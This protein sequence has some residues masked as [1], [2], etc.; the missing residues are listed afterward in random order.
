MITLHRVVHKST[1]HTDTFEMDIRVSDIVAF[2]DGFII[3]GSHQFN[4]S[5]D[6]YEI[7]KKITE[8]GAI[9]D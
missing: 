6:R 9:W 5:E 3:V 2:H 1:L 8:S 7:H 4:V